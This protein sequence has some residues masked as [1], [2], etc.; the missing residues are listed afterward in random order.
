MPGTLTAQE[1]TLSVVQELPCNSE[2]KATV[3]QEA[4]KS[5]RIYYIFSYSS[6]NTSL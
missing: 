1:A 5:S 4:Q 2:E 3:I 6:Y